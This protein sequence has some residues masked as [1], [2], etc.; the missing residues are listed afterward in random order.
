MQGSSGESKAFDLNLLSSARS[1]LVG[2]IFVFLVQIL[3]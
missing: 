1:E 2:Q 3:W